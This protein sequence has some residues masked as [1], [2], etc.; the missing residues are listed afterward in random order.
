MYRDYFDVYALSLTMKTFIAIG[1]NSFTVKI[2]NN[3]K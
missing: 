2:K 3:K 1:F